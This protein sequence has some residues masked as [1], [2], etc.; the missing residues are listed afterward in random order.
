[1]FKLKEFFN[2]KK[3]SFKKLIILFM[4]GLVGFIL[5]GILVSL[6]IGSNSSPTRRI[7]SLNS[8]SNQ[9]TNQENQ[10]IRSTSNVDRNNR[11]ILAIQLN[12][13]NE[14]LSSMTKEK[15]A[16]EIKYVQLVNTINDNFK[17]FSADSD[18]LNKRISIL[19]SKLDAT[20]K[21]SQRVNI[22][23]LDNLIQQQTIQE[24]KLE[25]YGIPYKSPQG[26]KVNATVGNRAW[27]QTKNGE[28]SVT[29]GDYINNKFVV[30]SVDSKKHTVLIIQ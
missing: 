21:D 10:Q 22:V 25:K 3:M 11:D 16:L 9:P 27:I 15:E 8:P 1:M 26:I 18:S 29:E 12:N 24:N 20:I 17:K 4:G 5:L 23:R 14:E 30:K 28:I 7:V 2:L 19:E 13:R 6:S